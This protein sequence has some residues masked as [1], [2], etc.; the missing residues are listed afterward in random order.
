VI[1]RTGIN[2]A[3]SPDGETGGHAT[4]SKVRDVYVL[5]SSGELR[6]VTDMTPSML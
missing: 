5:I 6:R 4:P 3:L 2:G 1:S